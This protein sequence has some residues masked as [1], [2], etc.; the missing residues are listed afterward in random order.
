MEK[1]LRSLRQYVSGLVLNAGGGSEPYR[2]LGGEMINVDISVSPEVDLVCD[3]NSTLP[4]RDDT[5]DT[6]LAI[7]VLEHL[8]SP[9]HTLCELNRVLRPG[10]III[11]TVP[12]L[13]PVHD[14]PRDYWRFTP[15]SLQMLFQE[16]EIVV[17]EP[18]GGKGV[19]LANLFHLMA[20]PRF[21]RRLSPAVLAL[22]RMIDGLSASKESQV[23]WALGY[24][25]VARRA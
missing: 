14:A 20:V 7:S 9:W 15:D 23:K 1:H 4:F 5:F 22:A 3:L 19:V 2:W 6:V 10:G 17:N 11:V 18:I 25:V 21:L 8:P 16:W 13:W 24:V 12:L